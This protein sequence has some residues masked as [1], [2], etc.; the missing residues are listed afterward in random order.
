M[1]YFASQDPRSYSLYFDLNICFGAR[2]VSGAFEKRAPS[3]EMCPQLL[4][5]SLPET[6]RSQPR[7]QGSP[8]PG[9]GALG[10][11]LASVSYWPRFSLSLVTVPEVIAQKNSS[12][13]FLA[14]VSKVTN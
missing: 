13:F 3:A 10:T 5:G 2:K 6:R 1:E 9:K 4:L 14:M 12:S 8:K 11:R 7:P